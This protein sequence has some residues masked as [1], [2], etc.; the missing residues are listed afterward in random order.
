MAFVD[1][2]GDSRAE[3]AQRNLLR[4]DIVLPAHALSRSDPSDGRHEMSRH[5]NVIVPMSSLHAANG[6]ADAAGKI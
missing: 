6:Y 1:D 3:S 5:A 4:N 2:E